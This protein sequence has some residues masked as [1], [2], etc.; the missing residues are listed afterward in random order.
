MLSILGC[1][2]VHG[3]LMLMIAKVCDF[4]SNRLILEIFAAVCV[5]SSFAIFFAS[6]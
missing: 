6:G 4:D 1:N 2:M 5:A 3:S